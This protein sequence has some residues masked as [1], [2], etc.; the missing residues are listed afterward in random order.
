MHK[1]FEKEATARAP[2]R[3]PTVLRREQCSAADSRKLARLFR[4]S[5]VF[6]R[7]PTYNF[8]RKPLEQQI[9]SSTSSE[10]LLWTLYNCHPRKSS[11]ARRRFR[12]SRES[13]LAGR[14]LSNR[15]RTLS[16]AILL[17]LLAQQVENIFLLAQQVENNCVWSFQRRRHFYRSAESFPPGQC[18]STTYAKRSQ[19]SK[20]QKTFLL[21]VILIGVGRGGSQDQVVL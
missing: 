12:Q 18:L 7:F 10:H 21:V 6:S 11:A 20:P 9:L 19:R 4:F 8:K 17:I 5:T 13:L 16:H 2:L 3:W 1:Y 14:R 15:A